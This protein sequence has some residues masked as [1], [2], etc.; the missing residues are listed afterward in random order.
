MRTLFGTILLI[1]AFLTAG[2]TPPMLLHLNKVSRRQY[3]R[4]FRTSGASEYGAVRRVTSQFVAFQPLQSATCEDIPVSEI[5]SWKG[6]GPKAS[7][8][9][10]ALSAA[11]E[12]T[13]GAPFFGL[14]ESKRLF[15][16]DHSE[17]LQGLWESPA[18]A[19][20]SITQFQIGSNQIQKSVFAGRSGSYQVTGSSL[21]ISS[22]PDQNGTTIVDTIPFHFNCGN[23]V[24]GPDQPGGPET[25]FEPRFE[26]N[27]VDQPIVGRWLNAGRTYYWEF[28]RDGSC[29]KSTV[30]PIQSSGTF[31]RLNGKVDVFWELPTSYVEE[32]TVRKQRDKLTILQGGVSTTYSRPRGPPY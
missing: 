32:W 26:T 28:H 29:R 8:I 2:Q 27:L 14:Y 25:K 21:V 10:G 23:L 9:G 13:L 6:E 7:E 3:V 22:L 19:D 18:A 11:L 15:T 24:T 5:A 4:L 17:P 31:K 12:V 20:G 1:P 30:E 16:R